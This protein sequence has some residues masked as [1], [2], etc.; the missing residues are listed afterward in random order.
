MEVCA[1]CWEAGTLR[2]D[3]NIWKERKEPK[4]LN[5]NTSE[6][7]QFL[8]CASAAGSPEPRSNDVGRIVEI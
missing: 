8:V 3:E 5:P 2:N 6:K 1:V 4:K 7:K